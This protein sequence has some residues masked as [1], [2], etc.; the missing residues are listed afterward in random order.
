[1]VLKKENTLSAW[2]VHAAFPEKRSIPRFFRKRLLAM[3]L[4]WADCFQEAARL[5]ELAEALF[6]EGLYGNKSDSDFGLFFLSQAI[7]KEPEKAKYYFLRG[8]S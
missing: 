5:S 7:K 3:G 2:S 8:R 1:M 4:V 6:K